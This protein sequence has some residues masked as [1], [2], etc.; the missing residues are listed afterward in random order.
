MYL[1]LKAS[2]V[3]IKVPNANSLELTAFLTLC[4]TER[5]VVSVDLARCVDFHVTDKFSNSFL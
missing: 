3:S 5:S 2:S 4:T 1:V